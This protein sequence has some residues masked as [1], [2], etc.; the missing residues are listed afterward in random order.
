[1]GTLVNVVVVI[2]AS[3]IGLALRTKLSKDAE[4]VICLALG[5]AAI[6]LGVSFFLSTQNPLIPLFSLPLG[7]YLGHVAGFHD[8]LQPIGDW[9]R[10][11]FRFLD[12][13]VPTREGEDFT[14]AFVQ[15]TVVSLVG[16][17]AILG[18]IQEGLSGDCNFLYT[19][20][21]F[22]FF[23]TI[24]FAASWG[25]GVA[26]S[27]LPILFFQEALMFGSSVVGGVFTEPII[28][29]M[30]AVGGVIIMAMG[31]SVSKIK[32]L[33]MGNFIP[34]IFITPLVYWVLTSVFTY[35]G[36]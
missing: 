20:C 10:K 30:A 32:E 1:M 14:G 26:F 9:L 2:F 28:A 24:I 19:K 22:D 4:R 29:E 35:F 6:P 36:I 18:P 3:V 16:P 33:K 23:A 17:L 31:I 13:Y 34:A 25:K 8:R 27:A 5:L 12:T 21:V 11:K 15:A 7:L